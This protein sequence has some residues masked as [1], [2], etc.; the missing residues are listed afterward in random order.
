MST[1]NDLSLVQYKILLYGKEFNKKLLC[2]TLYQ[3]TKF[4]P[5]QIESIC[6]QQDK[7]YQKLKFGLRK[8]ENIMGKGEN[9]GYQHFLLFPQC[10]QKLPFLWA[11][12]VRIFR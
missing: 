10:S 4:R 3:T 9:T 8:I 5:V 11:L 12:K 1:A 6:T 7:C 2:L